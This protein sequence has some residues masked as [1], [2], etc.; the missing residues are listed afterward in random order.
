MSVSIDSRE[1]VVDFCFSGL[2][3]HRERHN[4][5]EYTCNLPLGEF[6]SLSR[7]LKPAFVSAKLGTREV[8]NIEVSTV[9]R[10]VFVFYERDDRVKTLHSVDDLVP[11]T[12]AFSEK[13]GRDGILTC[14]RLD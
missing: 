13:Y 9:E 3:H 11:S 8:R 12:V 2:S 4:V 6:F 1:H 7:W 10:W 14:D 5:I